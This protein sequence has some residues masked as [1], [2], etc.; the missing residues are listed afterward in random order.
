[1]KK[2]VIAP[3]PDD[4]I[5]GCGGYLLRSIAKGDIISWLIITGLHEKDGWPI[6]RIKSREQEVEQ[7]RR[8]LNISPKNFYNLNLST[9]KLDQY[10]ISE[11]VKLISEVFQSF[12]PEEIILPHP[13]DVHS[14][15]RI[16]FEASISS[17]KWFR[18]PFIKRIITY[19]TISETDFGADPRYIPFKPNIFIDIS[20]E[21]KEKLKIM[22]TYS[23]EIGSFP[24][25]RSID[26][27]ASQAKLRGS[28]SGFKAAEAFCLIKEIIN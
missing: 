6:D 16:V 4:E 27:I 7:V 21:L 12:R 19:E 14:D 18:Y 10:P 8:K 23:S 11:L 26:S 1:M 5:L 17:S 2:L 13:G 22:E 20:N 28:Q 9:T 15:H 25:P 3:H 24:F